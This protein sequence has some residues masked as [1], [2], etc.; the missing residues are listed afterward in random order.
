[1]QSVDEPMGF[2]EFPPQ[3]DRFPA[4]E[5]LAACVGVNALLFS[6]FQFLRDL[7]DLHVEAMQ[8]FPRLCGVGVFTHGGILPSR[9]VPRALNWILSATEWGVPYAA[10]K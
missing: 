7:L 10:P 1:M 5:T 4:G 8:Q 6:G 2:V 9:W 3:A